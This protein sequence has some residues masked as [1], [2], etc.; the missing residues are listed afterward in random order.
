MTVDGGVVAALGVDVVADVT[1][2]ALDHVA[3]EALHEAGD[4]ISPTPPQPEP[5]PGPPEA[6]PVYAEEVE[7]DLEEEP[8]PVIPTFIPRIVSGRAGSNCTPCLPA[9]TSPALRASN[10]KPTIS[11]Y[12]LCI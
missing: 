6:T 3:A 1:L 8:E 9:S 2:V 7:D 12:L 10:A 11:L 5:S 4:T